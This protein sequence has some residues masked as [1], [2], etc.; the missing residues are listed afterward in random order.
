MRQLL[1]V[2]AAA[3]GQYRR[4]H[5]GDREV[6]PPDAIR[7]ELAADLSRRDFMRRAGG[8]GLG[9]LVLGALPVV[10]GM[11]APDPAFAQGVDSDGTLQAFFDTMIP[12]KRVPDLRTELG[13][14][15]HPDAILGVDREH[16]AVY[17]DS[18]RLAQHPKIGFDALEGPFLAELQTRS[19]PEGGPFLDLDYEARER[20]CRAGLDEGNPTLTLWIAA[21]AIP[22]TAFTAAANIKNATRRTAAGYRVMGHPGAAR[23]G[24]RDF[25]YGRRLNRGRTRRGYLP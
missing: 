19:L 10:E 4:S 7:N 20:V 23:H 6:I 9:T 18:L 14:P 17:T 11:A 25:S 13:S 22:F 3:A 2:A 15:I 21:A 12:G 1:A 5:M 16:G 8:L 24:Y